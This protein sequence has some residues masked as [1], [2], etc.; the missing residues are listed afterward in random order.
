MEIPSGNGLE[1]E[2]ERG[3]NWLFCFFLHA[4]H[5]GLCVNYKGFCLISKAL[6]QWIA[7]LGWQS[8]SRPCYERWSTI[9]RVED[10]SIDRKTINIKWRP[11]W[12]LEWGRAHRENWTWSSPFHYFGGTF[13]FIFIMYWMVAFIPQRAA[14][15]RI[16]RQLQEHPDTWTQVVTILQNSQNLNTKFYAL[17]V[18]D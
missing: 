9:S 15:E 14:A 4:Q 17:Q 1:R 10:I 12:S 3:L 18:R 6:S 8:P 2:R 13:L 16:L 5:L 11:I 7:L